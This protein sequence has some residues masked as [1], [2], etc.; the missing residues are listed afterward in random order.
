MKYAYGIATALLLFTLNS[1]M[2]AAQSWERAFYSSIGKSHAFNSARIVPVVTACSVDERNSCFTQENHC[3]TNCPIGSGS[4]NCVTSCC[5]AWRS[6][7]LLVSC[8]MT[9]A[10]TCGVR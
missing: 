6:C 8:N 5:M 4:G 2:A 7:M 1:G 3:R 10:R 9:N